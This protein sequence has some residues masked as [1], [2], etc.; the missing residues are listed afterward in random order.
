MSEVIEVSSDLQIAGIPA[1]IYNTSGLSTAAITEAPEMRQL[2]NQLSRWVDNARAAT[3]RHSMFDRGAYTPPANPYDEMRAARHAV[4]YDN[5]VA[6]V[7]EITEALAF[8][9]LKWEGENADDADVFNQW[10][11]DVDL[12]NVVRAMW[13]DEF[14]IAQT[15][16]A[17]I[18]GWKNYTVRGKTKKGNARKKSYR[19][20]CPVQ[21]RTLNPAR[22]VPIDLG[23]LGGDRIA[24]ASTVEEVGY[25]ESVILGQRDDPLMAAFF[26]GAY[27]P[28][29]EDRRLLASWGVDVNHLLLIDG[30]WVFRHCATKGNFEPF[31]E[32]R[33]KSCF[34]LLDMKTQLLAADR[35]ALIG[36]ANYILLVKKGD[37][38][39]P[40]KQEEMDNLHRNYNVIAR[41]PVIIA[42]HR[43]NIEII[44]PKTDLTLIP[45]KY[46]TLD[47]RLLNRLLGTLTV[48]GRG[49][50]NETQVTISEIVAKVM[51]NRRHLLKRALEREIARSIVEHP[52]N[53]GVFEDEPNLVFTPRNIS[54]EFSQSMIQGLIALRTQR[55]ISRETLLECFGLDQAT[56]AQRLEI[57][58]DFFDDI[59]KTM[60]LPGQMPPGQMPGQNMPKNP[61]PNGTGE[62][63]AVSG[64]R[65]GRPAGGGTTPNNPVKKAAPKSPKGNQSTR[66]AAEEFGP[67]SDESTDQS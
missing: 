5:I 36:N 34:Q 1:N 54:L 31:P 24:W 48:G 43:L 39:V 49:Q 52:K 10:S 17:K 7:A 51:E 47:N 28:P 20:W 65:G 16:V 15:V 13:R 38:D 14:A 9:G 29:A 19:V 12:D 58:E 6:G 46:E 44:A 64:A 60:G 3:G 59:F 33:L 63:P 23:P 8:V 2:A 30:E 4:R 35:A 40:A 45:E 62:A 50:R 56:E 66:T 37:K 55:E 67:Q 18:W 53:E 42:D 25:Y 27:T 61:G 21:L 57:E 32:P 11:R 22:C 41:T 26:D